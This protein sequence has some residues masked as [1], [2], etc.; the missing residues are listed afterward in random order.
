M[1]SVEEITKIYHTRSGE[2][3]VLDRVSFSIKRGQTIAFIGRNGAGKSTLMRI[4]S[5]A[6]Y[7]TSGVVRREMSVSWPLGFGAGFQGS[8]TGADNARFIARI[9]GVDPDELL[10]YVEEFAEL[11]EYLRMPVKTYSSGM[12]GRL[13]FGV[14]LA[15]HFD[16]YLVDEVTGAG[17]VRFRERAEHALRE[18]GENASMIMISHEAETLRKYCKMGALIAD[19][20]LT[21]YDDLEEA[22]EAYAALMQ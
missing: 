2:R 13:A 22:L 19:G 5:G 7:A 15:I 4:I 10:A 8:L 6:E 14:S 11:G 3:L 18:R 21:M 20:K 1:I 12:R 9:Y 17:D 16:C